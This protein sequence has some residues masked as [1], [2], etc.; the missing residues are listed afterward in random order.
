[1][2]RLKTEVIGCGKVGHFHAKALAKLPESDFVAVCGR[3]LE[4]TKEFAA[5]YGVKA[6]DD[7]TKMVE[8]C[9]VDVVCICTPHPAHA[10]SAFPAAKAVA[11]LLIEKPLASSLEDCDTILRAAKENNVKVGTIVQRRFYRPCM[12]MKKAIEE[13]K[14]GTP[15][16]GRL[17]MLGWRDKNYYE[18]TRGAAHGMKRA[19][20]YW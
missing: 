2:K 15:I 12:R 20:A 17:T 11:H 8:E 6:Y 10:A 19:A 4:R 13:G 18:A 7:V 14:I 5:I 3:N 16:L 9:D 1:M